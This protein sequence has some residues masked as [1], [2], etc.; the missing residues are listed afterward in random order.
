MGKAWT[1][2][3]RYRVWS[4]TDW[5]SVWD[6]ATQSYCNLVYTNIDSKGA[7]LLQ[8]WCVLSRLKLYVFYTFQAFF[9][10]QTILKVSDG[11]HILIMIMI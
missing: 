3:P 4:T 9:Y 1:T 6:A 11:L 8:D 5:V 2:G 10:R 7:T